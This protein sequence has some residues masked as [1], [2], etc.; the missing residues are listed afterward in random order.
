[1]KITNPHQSIRI[2]QWI[3]AVIG[4]IFGL[5]FIIAGY[6]LNWGPGSGMS[7]PFWNILLVGLSSSLIGAGIGWILFHQLTNKLFTAEKSLFILSLK[8]FSLMGVATVAAT[9]T[10]WETGFLLGKLSGSIQGLGWKEVL[11]Y[12]PVMSIAYSIPICLV[13]SLIYA[14]F[15]S[16]CIN[17]RNQQ[18]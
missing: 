1:M 7:G 2:G 12:V 9:V 4:C 18:H 17:T 10:S 3:A 16:F 15:V 8:A 11:L 13:A 5:V 14:L 6:F